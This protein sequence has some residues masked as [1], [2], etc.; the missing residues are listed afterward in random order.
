MDS[1]KIKASMAEILKMPA[2]RI[3][4]DAV[5][6]DLVNDSFVL[7]DLVIE[8]QDEYDILIVQDD[9][10]TVNTVRDLSNVCLNKLAGTQ[11][12]CV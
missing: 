8:L 4:D 9:L 3:T 1:E 11:N 7:V 2:S 12:K 6:T 10:K 5:L